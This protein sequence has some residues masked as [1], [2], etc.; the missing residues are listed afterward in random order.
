MDSSIVLF[1][2]KA[3]KVFKKKRVVLNETH[4]YQLL[5]GNMVNCVEHYKKKPFFRLVS[6]GVVRMVC[7]GGGGV[8]DGDLL[9][10]KKENILLDLYHTF[11]QD[12]SS[13]L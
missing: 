9:E 11:T 3:K 4:C 2:R 6:P 1:G 8:K 13:L 7:V 12:R 10:V 5:Y